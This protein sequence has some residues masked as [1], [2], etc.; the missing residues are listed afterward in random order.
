MDKIKDLLL[1]D[2]S[3]DIKDVINLE[4]QTEAGIQFEVENYI[5]TAKIA[6]Y[7]DR[8]IQNYKSN[9]KETGVW[10]S[11]FYGSG[12]S[13]FGKMLGYLLE[14][15]IINGTPFRERFIQRLSGLDNQNLLENTIRSLDAY[16]TKVVFLD[17]AKQHTGNSF[18]WTLFRNFLH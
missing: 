12:K 17:I 16:Q 3:E 13:Y 5:I 8:F 4:E 18:A 15:K 2:F 14:N 6:N 11:G 1:L 10:V 7:F 9:I